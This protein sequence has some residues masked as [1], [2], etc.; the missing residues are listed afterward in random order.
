MNKKY[1]REIITISLHGV[2]IEEDNRNLNE[3]LLSIEL[4]KEEVN[5]YGK[6]RIITRTM[7]PKEYLDIYMGDDSNR[8]KS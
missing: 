1:E 2:E 4:V 8:N 6:N 5:S 3:K 7:G